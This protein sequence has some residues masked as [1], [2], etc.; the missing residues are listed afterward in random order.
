MCFSVW[1]SAETPLS[2]GLV[3][4]LRKEALTVTALSGIVKVYVPSAPGVQTTVLP[5]ASVT[6]TAE[7]R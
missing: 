1:S 2:F 5:P 7:S 4:S 3:G 6:V